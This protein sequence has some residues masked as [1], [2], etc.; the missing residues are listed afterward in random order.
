MKRKWFAL[1]FLVIAIV[2]SGCSSNSAKEESATSSPGASSSAPA[3]TAKASQP[4]SKVVWFSSVGFWNPP[5]TW[6][7][8]PKTI[9]GAITEKTGLTFNF[10]IPAQDGETKLNLMLVSNAEMPDLITTTNDALGRKLYEAGKVWDLDEFLKKYDPNSHLLKDFPGDVKNAIVAK[11]GAFY[12]FPSHI[13]SDDERKVYPPSDPTYI[14]EN[15]DYYQNNAVIVNSNLMKEAGI[16]LDELKTEEGL[17]AALQKVK[18]KKLTVN[19]AP[20]V[21]LMIH[22]K[23]SLIDPN[24][25]L[26]FTLQFL[27]N[28]FGGMPVDKDGNFR[29]ELLAPEMKNT[30][31][32]L[33]KAAKAHAFDPGQLTIDAS[34]VRTQVS[35]GQVFAFIGNAAD[36]G[37]AK[38]T[39]VDWVSPGAILSNAGAKPV[40]LRTLQ[41]GRGWMKTYI[42]KTTKEPEKITKFISF[43][44][45]KEGLMLNNYGFK[46]VHYSLND[47][48]LVIQTEQGIKDTADYNKTG[49]TAFWPFANISFTDS[50]TPV[51]TMETNREAIVAH[52]VSI[53]YGETPGVVPYDQSALWIPNDLFP[54]DS[55]EFNDAQEIKSYKQ[56]QVAKIVLAKDAAEFNKLYDEMIANLKKLGIDAIDAGKTKYFHEWS[57]KYGIEVTKGVNS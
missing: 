5:T 39:D 32:F 11:D 18:D 15:I 21:P 52:N 57:G 40:L 3:E 43:M 36:T 45:G 34:A 44:S 27:F 42:S 14:K 41:P 7:T 54:S 24:G 20:V 2:M 4:P 16:T 48:G 8:D 30:L 12:A 28:N 47:K 50:V 56:A 35:S 26:G 23:D 38:M 22:G 29:D 33:Y 37:F 6:D 1:V 17:L 10:D 25:N 53:V 46:G 31:E 49:L 51:P 13:S 9:T 55:K 19:G